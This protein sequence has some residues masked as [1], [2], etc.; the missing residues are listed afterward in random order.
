MKLLLA[1]HFQTHP[2]DP[3]PWARIAQNSSLEHIA[4]GG[5]VHDRYEGLVHDTFE[6]ALERLWRYDIFPPWR[7]RTWVPPKVICPGDTIVQLV[8][9][10]PLALETAVRVIEIARTPDSASLAYATL[11]G[12]PELG[13]ARFEIRRSSAEL[14]FIIEAWSR[15]GNTLARLGRPLARHLQR[16]ITREAIDHFC[17]PV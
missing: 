15:P 13:V 16:S 3:L 6:N 17:A 2:L 10:G 4:R 8:R 11:E 7:M 1:S 14:R 5:H 12:H 9:F